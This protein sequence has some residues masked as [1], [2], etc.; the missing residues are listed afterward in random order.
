MAT[1]VLTESAVEDVETLIRV[2]SLPADTKGRVA[3]SLRQLETFPMLGPSLAGRGEGLRFLLGPWRWLL[4]IYQVGESKD[5]VTVVSFQD[6]R[7]STALTA[8]R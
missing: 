6:A 5:Q 1:V 8:S 4:V 3:R 7:S 2:L